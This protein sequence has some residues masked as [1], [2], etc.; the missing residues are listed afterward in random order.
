MIIP[1]FVCRRRLMARERTQPVCDGLTAAMHAYGVPEQIFFCVSS[2][3]ILVGEGPS[4][5]C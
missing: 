4:L 2:L 5:R 3:L 1:G